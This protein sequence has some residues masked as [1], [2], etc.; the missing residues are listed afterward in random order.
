MSTPIKRNG[1]VLILS[2]LRIRHLYALLIIGVIGRENRPAD[3]FS[4]KLLSLETEFSSLFINVVNYSGGSIRRIRWWRL[5]TILPLSTSLREDLVFHFRFGRGPFRFLA[6]RKV[7]S[8]L[9]KT[10]LDLNFLYVEINKTIFDIKKC[11]LFES[12]PYF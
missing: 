5:V 3:R 8:F 7:R 4:V 10:C 2:C 12:I 9:L 11:L 1:I 6:R